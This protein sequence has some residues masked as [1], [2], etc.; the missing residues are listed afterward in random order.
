MGIGIFALS[1]KMA[2]LQWSLK[3]SITIGLISGLALLIGMSVFSNVSMINV[4]DTLRMVSQTREVEY[5][6]SKL[7]SL[8]L[9]L[10][11][12]RQNYLLTGKNEYRDI[13]N[14]LWK[15]INPEID[16]FSLLTND[17]PGQQTRAVKLK[18]LFS[19]RKDL[20]E[21]TFSEFEMQGSKVISNL[22]FLQKRDE[23]IND[24][25]R[26]INDAENEEKRLLIIREENSNAS[27]KRTFFLLPLGTFAS[28][29]IL[30][31]IFML[32][33]SEVT[34]RLRSEDA[35]KKSEEKLRLKNLYNRTLL[36]VSLDPLVTIS[37]E[38]K[39][40]DVNSAVE[41]I[42]GLSREELIGSD[43]S[44]YFTDRAKANEGYKKVFSD[45]SVHDYY[46][47]IQDKS[48]KKT[49]VLY[50]AVTYK[51]EE[52]K[53]EGVFAAARDI[54]EIKRKE[55][56]LSKAN[57]NLNRSNQELEQF[58]YVA[59]HDLQEPL[60]MVSS[61]TQLLEKRYSD[62][63]D[64]DAREFINYA[65]DGANRMQR[66][67]ND[68]LEYSRVTTKG[69]PLVK[70]DLSVVLG[71]AVSN[72][73]NKIQETG[74]VILNDELPCVQGD[75]IQLMQVFQNLIDNA[76]KFSRKELPRIFIKSKLKENIVI[77]SVQDNGIGID[78]KYKDRIFVIFNRLHGSKA[79]PGTGI[80]LAICKRI[81]ERHGGKIWFDSEPGKGTTFNFYLNKI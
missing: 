28:L 77:I 41:K 20:L 18:Q 71:M 48:G 46:L 51:N 79:Y 44:N 3:R 40:T 73:R 10:E 60:R 66:L 76:I 63:L 16:K 81:I 65:V 17:N 25:T 58:V 59:S 11:Q 80:G 35:L 21:K 38:G 23:I 50:N 27:S 70:V 2:N 56:E 12:Q 34:E 14:N 31:W 78:Q 30:V 6:L 52:G 45:G 29:A 24:I 13:I 74:T 7:S 8:L 37:P 39:I 68:L 64:N 42:T 43:F 47:I 15:S 67:I 55:E 19:K 54:T 22:L 61:F 75:E 33:N 1:L 72:L 57:E 4:Q 5:Q 49:D 26:I 53:I 32:L 36:E 9:E 69:K 62:K